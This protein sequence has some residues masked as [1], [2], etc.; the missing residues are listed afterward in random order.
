MMSITLNQ[1]MAA[2]KLDLANRVRAL[3][4]AVI[5]TAL[6]SNYGNSYHALSEQFVSSP[7]ARARGEKS[8]ILHADLMQSF[9]DPALR[10]RSGL[11]LC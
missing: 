6:L 11:P 3:S 7:T 4:A 2:H 1:W 5:V 10:A 8:P 9:V